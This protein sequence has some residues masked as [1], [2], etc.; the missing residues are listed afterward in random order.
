M[1]GNMCEMVCLAAYVR[2]TARTLLNI[3]WLSQVMMGFHASEKADIYS[4]GIFI[5]YAR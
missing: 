5:W 1:A 2:T 4:F 3:S